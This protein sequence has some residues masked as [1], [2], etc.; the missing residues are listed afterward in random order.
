LLAVLA[1]SDTIVVCGLGVLEHEY[2]SLFDLV[3]DPQQRNRG[4]GAKL[5]VR[6]LRWAQEHAAVHGYLQVMHGN[7]PARHLYA[8]LGFADVY[9][10]WYRVPDA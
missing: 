5:V 9:Q 8:K 3:T 10:Y 2:F 6:M 7:D 4:Y 1:D